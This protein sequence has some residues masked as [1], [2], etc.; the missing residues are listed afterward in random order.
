MP[1]AT[2]RLHSLRLTA[3]VCRVYS[4]ASFAPCRKLRGHLIH[5]ELRL[6]RHHPRLRGTLFLAFNCPADLVLRRSPMN[7]LL[8]VPQNRWNSICVS[9]NCLSSLH[10]DTANLPGSPNLSLSLGSFTGSSLWL[11]D[12]TCLHL[13]TPTSVSA[14]GSWLYGVAIDTC[15]KPLSFDGR[16]RHMMLPFQGE[17]WALTAFTLSDVSCP[18][19]EFLGFPLPADECCPSLLPSPFGFSPSADGFGSFVEGATP[20]QVVAAR[21][22]SLFAFPPSP[23]L[24]AL[25]SG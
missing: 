8:C 21:C 6:L 3:L 2:L 23:P 11:E 4:T 25:A 17:R 20:V 24:C 13:D 19:L 7:Y 22:I 15:R 12:L 5:A 1:P 14:G 10:A 18:D 16:V 9:R